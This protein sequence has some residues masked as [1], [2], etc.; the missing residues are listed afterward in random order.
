M[1][2]GSGDS[3]TK[4]ER[5]AIDKKIIVNSLGFTKGKT[6]TTRNKRWLLEGWS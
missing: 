3:D 4:K 2:P 6:T 1:S 5:N